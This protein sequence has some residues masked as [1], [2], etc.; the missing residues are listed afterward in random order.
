MSRKLRNSQAGVAAIEFAIMLPFLLIVF[1]GVIEIS[2]YIISVRKA[3]IVA[4]DIAYLLSREGCIAHDGAD[5]CDTLITQGSPIF[6]GGATELHEIEDNVTPFLLYPIPYNPS[7][8]TSYA[9]D[10]SVAG[11]PS[12]FSS[13]SGPIVTC[14]TGLINGIDQTTYRIIWYDHYPF[15]NAVALAGPT[16]GQVNS[17]APC[18][19]GTICPF[20]C[21]GKLF[22][23]NGQNNIV[24]VST[25]IVYPGQE[26]I[27]LSFSLRYDSILGMSFPGAVK[28][29]N[30]QKHGSYAIRARNI[31]GGS[32][33]FGANDLINDMFIC[34]DCYVTS[35]YSNNNGDATHLTPTGGITAGAGSAV[36]R[37]SCVPKSQ[38]PPSGSNL[39]NSGGCTFNSGTN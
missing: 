8:T 26:F 27:N 33:T 12:N 38:A 20:A 23:S 32:G 25:D 35:S 6:K 24:G 1:Y 15:N 21:N 37:Q 18:S 22:L 5:S 9:F 2:N 34:T 17:A 10:V 19:A 29:F 11:L 14:P 7:D 4:N 16:G 28:L 39:Y 36:L 13:S 3:D 30:F 31:Y